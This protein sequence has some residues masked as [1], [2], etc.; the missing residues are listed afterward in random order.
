MY[1]APPP[2]QSASLT[3]VP[4]PSL[5]PQVA[6][7]HSAT[8]S[9][10]TSRRTMSTVRPCIVSACAV[11]MRPRLDARIWGTAGIRGEARPDF[12]AGRRAR[13][14]QRAGSK[15]AILGRKL[16]KRTLG[17]L[18]RG[19]VSY[20][21][22]NRKPDVPALQGFG[23]AELM[24]NAKREVKGSRLVVSTGRRKMK[25]RRGTHT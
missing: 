3:A 16:P 15:S 12:K 23:S 8:S 19:F 10:A 17:N 18:R 5:S 1:P 21:S 20:G 9:A 6:D 24:T 13:S 11:G 25:G 4:A 14:T 22:A 7:E 2:P